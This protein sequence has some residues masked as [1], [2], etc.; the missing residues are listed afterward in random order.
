MQHYLME[1]KENKHM[2][3]VYH[4]AREIIENKAMPQTLRLIQDVWVKL[5]QLNFSI[6]IIV[7]SN[8]KNNHFFFLKCTYN[9][10]LTW[11]VI[12]HSDRPKNAMRLT[13]YVTM[14]AETLL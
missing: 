14:I 1:Y 10:T 7:K 4:T 8:I 12:S 2:Q 5:S 6:I 11:L 13:R 3:D 9:S